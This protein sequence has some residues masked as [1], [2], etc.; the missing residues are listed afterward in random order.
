MQVWCW[1]TKTV[2]IIQT[3]DYTEISFVFRD[4]PRANI[5]ILFFEKWWCLQ[6]N[7]AQRSPVHRGNTDNDPLYTIMRPFTE[8]VGTQEN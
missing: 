4:H 5:H 3:F 6:A 1:I 8:D 7:T 2:C